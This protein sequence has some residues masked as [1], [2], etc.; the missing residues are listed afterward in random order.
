MYKY[1]QLLGC[2]ISSFFKYMCE[3][4]TIKRKKYKNNDDDEDDVIWYDDIYNNKENAILVSL[5]DT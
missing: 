2:K 5:I 3:T 4:F 1:I